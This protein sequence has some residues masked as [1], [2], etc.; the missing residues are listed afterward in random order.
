[1]SM[2]G[3]LRLTPCFTSCS[4]RCPSFCCVY[5]LSR[6]TSVGTIVIEYAQWCFHA[7]GIALFQA[8]PLI[9]GPPPVGLSLYAPLPLLLLSSSRQPFLA[10]GL[11]EGL[12]AHSSPVAGLKPTEAHPHHLDLVVS[13]TLSP[14]LPTRRSVCPFA[15][16]FFPP[17]WPSHP[18]YP[19]QNRGV[20]F[21]ERLYD[22][23]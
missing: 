21:L 6:T 10:A 20:K 8:R 16:D 11:S 2:L 13:L 23:L 1:M 18:S 4:R 7:T 12:D 22:P 19:T 14:P 17:A 9:L 3:S 5:R 15:S